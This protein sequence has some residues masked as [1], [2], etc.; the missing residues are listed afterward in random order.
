MCRYLQT[1]LEAD[2]YQVETASNG[3]QALE[4]VQR[5]PLPDLVL[6][7]VLM[8]DL[9]GLETLERLRQCRP[10]L[11]VVMLSCVSEPRRV[12]QAMRLGAT[13]YL[14]KPFQKAELDA[15]L[16]HWRRAQGALEEPEAQACEVEE[17]GEDLCFVAAGPA[18]RKIR[19]QAAQIANTDVP[20]LLLGES[21]TGKELVARL[22]H[23]MSSRSRRHV[24]KGQIA[25]PCPASCWK[26]SCLAMKR[27]LLRG[28]RGRSRA[29]S[30]SATRER[31]CWTRLGKSP[32]GCKQN[33]CMFC[34]TKNSPGWVVAPPSRWMCACWRQRTSISR[35]RLPPGGCA[36]ISTTV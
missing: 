16:N 21:G 32:R 15:V 26:A 20:V 6:L 1:L 25:Q 13:D 17:L 36:K 18:M 19:V 11:K 31:F 35:R 28:P 22:I 24:F 12:V 9:D 2:S 3:F 27:E 14:A 8:P 10:A 23:K 33:C 4:R 5:S 7:D 34:R 29:N 30:S